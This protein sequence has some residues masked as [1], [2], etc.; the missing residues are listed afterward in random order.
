LSEN[1]K[2]R[3][4][5]KGESCA[6]LL[7]GVGQHDPATVVWAHSPFLGDGKRMGGKAYEFCGCFACHPCHDIL[8]GRVKTDLERESLRAHFNEAMK[9]SLIRL[10]NG[11]IKPW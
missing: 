4:A 9:Q 11:G 2:I 10:W 5:A 3:Q 1:K 6:L 7:P 8:D